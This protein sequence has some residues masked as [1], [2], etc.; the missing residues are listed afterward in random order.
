MI[1]VDR[2]YDAPPE[3]GQAPCLV[4]DEAWLASVIDD[5][6]GE[7]PSSCTPPEGPPCTLTARRP[8]SPRPV[9]SDTGQA[10]VGQATSARLRQARRG[11]P[12]RAPPDR[13]HRVP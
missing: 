6:F 7:M 9:P 2:V 1:T 13:R 8:P 4:A 11:G 3:V 5:I 12:E 10:G